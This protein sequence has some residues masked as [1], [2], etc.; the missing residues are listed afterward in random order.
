MITE[1]EYKKAQKIVDEYRNQQLNIPLVRLS[2]PELRQMY[3]KTYDDMVR[4][5]KKKLMKWYKTEKDKLCK[6]QDEI[7]NRN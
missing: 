2:L 7:D 1:E 3:N 4:Y 6:I 5:K